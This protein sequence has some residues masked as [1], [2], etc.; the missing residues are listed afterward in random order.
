MYFS[1]VQ[2]AYRARLAQLAAQRREAAVVTLQRHWRGA[3]D[4]LR[5]R[6]HFIYMRR[7]AVILQTAWR[8]RTAR[9]LLHRYTL[10]RFS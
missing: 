6:E 9:L 10:F 3:I 7:A 4:T 8:A 2:R 1:G 5:Q